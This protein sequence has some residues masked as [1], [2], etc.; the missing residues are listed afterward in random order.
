MIDWWGIVQAERYMDGQKVSTSRNPKRKH[1]ECS[2]RA[3]SDAS[4][5]ERE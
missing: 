2:G 1:L 5:M 3:S 4:D